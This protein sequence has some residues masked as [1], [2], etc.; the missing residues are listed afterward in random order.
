MAEGHDGVP[1]LDGIPQL[2][3]GHEVQALLRVRCP[4]EPELRLAIW[5][6]EAREEVLEGRNCERRRG[7]EHVSEGEAE[8]GVIEGCRV[9]AHSLPD[10]AQRLRAL[11]RRCRC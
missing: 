4:V 11:V 9:I 10:G 2:N 6:R 5:R 1:Q 3:P 7:R 8:G